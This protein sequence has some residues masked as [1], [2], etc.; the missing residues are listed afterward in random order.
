MVALN[1]RTAEI[2]LEE[3]KDSHLAGAY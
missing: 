2:P 3:S 1:Q